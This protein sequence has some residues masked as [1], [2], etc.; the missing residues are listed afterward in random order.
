VTARNSESGRKLNGLLEGGFAT[1]VIKASES[2]T[3]VI[4]ALRLATMHRVKRLSSIDVHT[5][6][7]NK[8]PDA[9][10][11]ILNSRPEPESSR[12]QFEQTG[13]LLLHVAATRA[14]KGY[15]YFPTGQGS[16]YLKC[17]E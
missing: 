5:Q 17:R 7:S 11:Y 9:Y 4:P 14:K 13:T 10:R 6:G 8:R 12:E 2:M 3:R 16:P 1:R 15:G